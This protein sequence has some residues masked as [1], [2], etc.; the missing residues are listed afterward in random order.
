MVCSPNSAKSVYVDNEIRDT[1]VGQTA[2]V[3]PDTLVHSNGITA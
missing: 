3:T 1:S 2:P